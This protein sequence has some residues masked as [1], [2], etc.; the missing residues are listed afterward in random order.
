VHSATDFEV[1]EIVYGNTPYPTLLGID[2]DFE[3][4][5]VIDLKKIHTI[6]EVEDLKVT[7]SLDPT[8]GRRYVEPT[9][10]KGVDKMYNI[11]ARMED[12]V[13]PTTDGILSWR[14]I[15]SC[16]SDLEETMENWKQRLHEVSTRKCA[17]ITHALQWIGTEIVEPPRYDGLTDVAYFIRQ[18]ELQ[19]SDQQIL[20]SLDVVLKVTLARWWVV[21]KDGIK[22]WQ[23]CKK[24]L[25]VRFGTKNEYVMQKYT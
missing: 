8:E 20:L 9:K 4:H 21:H 23:Q 12:Y 13:N 11:T 22:Y 16:A 18:I 19:I 5:M 15:I 3:N 6:F 25:Q 24:L 14:S 17:R 10:R 7:A 2:W 1:I